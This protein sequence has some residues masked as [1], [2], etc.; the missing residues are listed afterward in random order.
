MLA[1]NPT[2]K[3]VFLEL[4]NTLH[5]YLTTSSCLLRLKQLRAKACTPTSPHS[6]AG[7]RLWARGRRQN[8]FCRIPLSH[9][10]IELDEPANCWC[11]TM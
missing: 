1:R 2:V 8:G 5:H 10:A 11:E 6:N 7:A 3:Y 4:A 9:A